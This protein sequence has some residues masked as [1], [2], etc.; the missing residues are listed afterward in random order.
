MPAQLVQHLTL[1]GVFELDVDGR[2]DVVLGPLQL[3]GRDPDLLRLASG[4]GLPVV[5]P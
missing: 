3:P 4:I 1:L 2:D 5:I